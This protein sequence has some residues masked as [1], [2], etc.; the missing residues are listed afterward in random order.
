MV[1]IKTVAEIAQK[2]GVNLGR[3][4]LSKTAAKT[5]RANKTSTIILKKMFLPVIKGKKRSPPIG[6]ITLPQKLPPTI[7]AKNG[8]KKSPHFMMRTSLSI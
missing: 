6:K 1:S 8:N 2:T 3:K 4:R 5:Q 7:R